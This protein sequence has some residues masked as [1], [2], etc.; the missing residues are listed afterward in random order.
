MAA[1]IL[2]ISFKY[3]VTSGEYRA[4]ADSLAGEFA[5]VGGLKWK[6][7]TIN[8]GES[9][10]G[11]VYYF[12]SDASLKAF[13]EGPLAAQVTSHP[14]LTDLSARVFDIVASA[15]SVTRGPV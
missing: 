12:D 11:G 14:A 9:T 15:T 8:E 1:Q 4:M 10:A 6:V 7:W 13:L 5:K 3:N 2:L